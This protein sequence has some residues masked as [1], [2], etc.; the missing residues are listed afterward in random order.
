MES[1]SVIQFWMLGT[2]A[3]A[4]SLDSLG[5]GVAYGL[6]KTRV[7]P[8]AHVCI[9]LVM[10]LIT[11]A[12]ATLGNAVARAVPEEAGKIL[13]AVVFV[14]LGIWALAPML[15]RKR[16][17]ARDSEPPLKEQPP[18]LA[19]T[20]FDPRLADRDGSRDIDLREAFLLGA[21]LSLNNIGGGVS[22][23]LIH[24]SAVSMAALS[25]LF[26]VLFLVG[27]HLVGIRL[28]ETRLSAYTRAVSGLL[29]VLIGLWQLH[30][31]C[32]GSDAAK[33]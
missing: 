19:A 23:G 3:F 5:V 12:A 27:G 1:L 26:N 32:G 20:L 33:G 29:L 16:P 11:W 9:G 13:S 21:A 7:G 15:R 28:S 30:Y 25:V 10:F 2:L 6:S 22:A 14:G 17:D 8:K 18:S 4:T 31:R 24:L